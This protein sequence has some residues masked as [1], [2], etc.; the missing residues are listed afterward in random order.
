MKP[1][2]LF[3]E[4]YLLKQRLSA[5]LTRLLTQMSVLLQDSVFNTTQPV[6]H[7]GQQLILVSGRLE[8]N[9]FIAVYFGKNN[10]GVRVLLSCSEQNIHF[11]GSEISSCSGTLYL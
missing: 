6:K 3:R 4:A 9:I 1:I 7:A 5:K 8:C 11:L 2:Y 10:V